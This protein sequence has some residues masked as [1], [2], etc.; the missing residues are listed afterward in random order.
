M[1]LFLAVSSLKALSLIVF[2]AE[3]KVLDTEILPQHTMADLNS[4]SSI[5]CF[6]QSVEAFTVNR[7]KHTYTHTHTHAHTHAHTQTDYNM[8]ILLRFNTSIYN[9]LHLHCW[10]ELSDDALNVN[11]LSESIIYTGERCVSNS[12][13]EVTKMKIMLSYTFRLS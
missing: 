4:G 1:T 11:D 5:Y 6:V 3:T 8:D 9:V 10:Y 13:K 2:E 12:F 7:Y